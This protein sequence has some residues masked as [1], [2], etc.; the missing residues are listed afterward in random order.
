MIKTLSL[1]ELSYNFTCP[2]PL[3]NRLFDIFE[4]PIPMFLEEED[5]NLFKDFFIESG[6][7]GREMVPIRMK[8][9]SGFDWSEVESPLYSVTFNTVVFAAF[10]IAM[11]FSS[12]PDSTDYIDL[13]NQILSTNYQ[14]NETEK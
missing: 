4:Q 9:D 10:P 8:F 13:I 1:T 11:V 3:S 2:S 6:D 5:L 7:R 14:R 12:S